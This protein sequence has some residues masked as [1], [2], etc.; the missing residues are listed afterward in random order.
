MEPARLIATSD[1]IGAGVGDQVVPGLNLPQFLKGMGDG[2]LI[3]LPLGPG[4]Q[5]SQLPM[6]VF[7]ETP[8]LRGDQAEGSELLSPGPPSGKP[9]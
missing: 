6:V 1:E 5:V 4:G 3:Q 7:T 2:D 8:W 9:A